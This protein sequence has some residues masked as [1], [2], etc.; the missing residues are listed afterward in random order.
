MFQREPRLN[1]HCFNVLRFMGKLRT[2]YLCHHNLIMVGHY[3]VWTLWSKHI[4]F[5]LD[6]GV[7]NILCPCV[8]S[9][10]FLSNLLQTLALRS[11]GMY[12]Y[13]YNFSKNYQLFFWI[14]SGFSGSLSA[15]QC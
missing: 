2:M 3:Y 1:E 14:Y 5:S 13:C 4:E 8:I 9:P 10:E 15:N 12:D 6:L 7:F 11:L